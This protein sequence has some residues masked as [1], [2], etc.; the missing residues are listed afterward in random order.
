M[1][2]RVYSPFSTGKIQEFDDGTQELDL[3]DFVV[4]KTQQDQFVTPKTD[5]RL[6]TIAFR[7]YRDLVPDGDKYYWVICVANDI[8]MALDEEEF[9]G[10]EI[11]VPNILDFKLRN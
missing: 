5:E 7:S 10:K 8:E 2:V 11:I 1:N 9:V 6:D 3:G 4:Q